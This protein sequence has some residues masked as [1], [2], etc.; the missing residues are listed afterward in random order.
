MPEAPAYVRRNAQRGLRL[1]DFAGDGLQA[2]TVRAARRMAAGEVSDQK[3]RLMGPWFARHEGDLD[4]PRARA[5]LAGDSERPTAGQVAWL[6]W[7]GDIRGDVMRAARWARRQTETDDRSTPS[8]VID[9]PKTHV[10]PLEAPPVSYGHPISTRHTTTTKKGATVRLL[11]QLV[12]ER[13]ELSETVDGMLTRAADESRDLSEV[14]D[15]NLADLKAR[16]DA[17]DGRITELRAVQVANLEAAK[18]RAEVAATDEPE[19]RS[20][21]G[22]VQVHSEPITYSERSNHSFFSDMYHAQTYGDTDAQGRLAR[23]REEMAVEHRDGTTA[24]FAGLVV[25]QF[26]TQLAADLARAGRPFADQCTSLPL[27]AD[28][29][30]VNVSRVTTGSSAA[31]QAA[32]NDAVSETDID[33]TLLTSSI[34]SIAAGQQLSRQAVERGT[35]VDALVAA[36]MIGAM[37]TALDSQLINGSGSSGQLLGL[38]NVSGVNSIT[39]TSGSPTAAALYAKIVDGIQQVNSNRFAGAD[40]IVMHPRRL[41]FMQAGVDSSNRPLV[42]PAQNVPTNAMGVGPVS[43]Y[44]VTGASIAGLPVVTDANIQT[45]AG[46][47]NNEDLIF[48]VRRADM[49]LFEDAGAPA[50]VRMDQTA[51][52]SLTVTMIAYQY[53]T[54]IPGRYPASISKISGTGLVTPTF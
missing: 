53:A 25:P 11:D 30:T 16:A 20:A 44:G 10:A 33:D 21:A 45:D 41:A 19:A 9:S 42:V 47:G 27:P 46:S 52:L 22:V 13:A 40:L 18:L 37:A 34:A 5:Y 29:M 7:G 3:A 8:S 51:G 31:V 14:E 38:K 26:L 36:D 17:L 48:I 50:L 39:Y 1:L 32:E 4:S 23:H 28:G 43:G 2:S 6:L 49:L 35:G 15:K 54:F 24:S 12:E